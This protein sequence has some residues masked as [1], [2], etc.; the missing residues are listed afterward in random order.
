MLS[1]KIGFA[2]FPGIQAMNMAVIT[3]FEVANIVLGEDAYDVMLVSEEGGSVRSSVGF[4]VNTEPFG[5]TIFDTVIIGSGMRPKPATPRPLE[6]ARRLIMEWMSRVTLCG[7]LWSIT[8]EQAVN[9]SI[10]PYSN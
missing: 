8:G 9:R 1:K 3:A 6:F 5:D 4:C 2:V 7:T 10:R